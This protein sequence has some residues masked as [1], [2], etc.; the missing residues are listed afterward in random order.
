MTSGN[1]E[2]NPRGMKNLVVVLVA[3]IIAAY[4]V[5]LWLN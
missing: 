4:L 1:G 2:R 3:A 5:F